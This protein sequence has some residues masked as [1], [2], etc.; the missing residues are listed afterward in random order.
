MSMRIHTIIISADV[1][2]GICHISNVSYGISYI[3]WGEGEKANG[4]AHPT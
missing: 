2:V 1:L 3:L 4:T